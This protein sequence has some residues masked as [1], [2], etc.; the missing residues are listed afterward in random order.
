MVWLKAVSQEGSAPSRTVASVHTSCCYC[1]KKHLP[2]SVLEGGR[3]LSAIMLMRTNDARLPS[4]SVLSFLWRQ[5]GRKGS[6]CPLLELSGALWLCSDESLETERQ[7]E[8]ERFYPRR[9]SMLPWLWGPSVKVE[10]LG[11]G[12][13]SGSVHIISAVRHQHPRPC[14]WMMVRGF[15]FW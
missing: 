10:M 12:A 13:V 4:C 2:T 9:T 8:R 5:Q 3:F 6:R 7:R 15:R 14:H 11:G 1:R